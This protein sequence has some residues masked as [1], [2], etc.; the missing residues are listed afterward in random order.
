MFQG[1]IVG[2]GLVKR[3][4]ER[5]DFRVLGIDLSGL[6]KPKNGDSVAV[7]GT[8][9]TATSS[10]DGI[11]FFDV[12]GETI[13]KT[14]LGKLK[15]GDKVNLERPINMESEISGHLVQGHVESVASVTKRIEEGENVRMSFTIPKGLNNYIFPKGS[16]A[17]DGISLTVVDVEKDFSVALIPETLKKTTLGFKKKGD[18]VNIET[19]FLVKSMFNQLSRSFLES[20][21]EMKEKIK[22]LESKIEKIERGK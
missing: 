19:D 9:L 18:L 14:N 11:T 17:I 10:S 16:I 3:I 15:V 6:V 22:K 2:T 5:N 20:I 7:N 21:E 4:E 13:E 1:I 12:I 8:C